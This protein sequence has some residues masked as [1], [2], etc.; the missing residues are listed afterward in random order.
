MI[1]LDLTADDDGPVLLDEGP[2]EAIRLAK[3]YDVA[4]AGATVSLYGKDRF[5]YSLIRLIQFEMGRLKCTVAEARQSI[6]DELIGP[7]Q[8]LHPEDGP[9][10]LDDELVQGPIDEATGPQIILPPDFEK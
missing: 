8:R 4:L 7:I 9:L 1:D 6:A 10:F 2:Q 5:V 3:R